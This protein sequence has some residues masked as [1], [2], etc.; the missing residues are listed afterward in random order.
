[1]QKEYKDQLGETKE[2]FGSTSIRM[3]PQYTYVALNMP[4]QL[5]FKYSRYKF[6]AK[7]IGEIPKVRILELGCGEGLGT[8]LLAENCHEVVG[9]DID[10]DAIEWAKVT[11]KE[12]SNLYFETDD[13]IGK[14]YG[15]FDVVVLLDVI[16]HIPKESEKEMFE[17]I[18]NNLSNDGYCIVGTPNITASVYAS[19]PSKVGHINLFDAERLRDAMS[20]YFK[21]VFMFG[22]NDE[23]V[24]TGFYPMCQY[25][26]VIGCNKK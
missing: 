12:K 1:M 5:L 8:I 21:N 20:K 26:L 6:C 4:R 9:I 16:E 24:H 3:G 14:T 18:V 2:V 22:M 25:L 19:S 7:M 11:L 13:F 17:G 15:I 10:N 23:V